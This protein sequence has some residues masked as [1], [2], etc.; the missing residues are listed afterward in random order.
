[1]QNIIVHDKLENSIKKMQMFKNNINVSFDEVMRH[2]EQ[3]NYEFDTKNTEKFRNLQEELDNKG[4]TFNNIYN[5]NMYVLDRNLNMYLERARKVA[6]S[7]NE[8]I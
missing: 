2:L 5:N 3:I 7:F 1:M 8:M 6:E 4:R